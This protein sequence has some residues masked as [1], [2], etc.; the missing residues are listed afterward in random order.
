MKQYILLAIVVLLTLFLPSRL[1]KSLR[2]TAFKTVSRTVDQKAGE[3]DR[4][5]S[6]NYALR[7]QLERVRNW[8]VAEESLERLKDFES[9]IK[10]NA[11]SANVVHREPGSWGAA[12]WIDR[13]EN[14]Q[15]KEES[16]VLVNGGV[17]GVVEEVEKTRSRVRL[18]TD[19]RLVPSVRV[20]RGALQ[21]R[22]LIESIEQLLQQL[23]LRPEIAS[24]LPDE[25][26]GLKQTLLGENEN[27]YLAK[28]E[29]HGASGPLWH[30]LKSELTGLGFNYEFPD[31]N[32]DCRPLTD[33]SLLKVGDL[34]V[35]TGMD[36]VFPP[37]L[38]IAVITKVD[39]LHDGQVSYS[40][41]ASPYVTSIAD[42]NTVQV[43][44][45]H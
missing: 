34:L 33:S 45:V 5:R 19:S 40:L 12:L 22:A 3:L 35:T 15:I 29:L 37:D 44:S 42:I 18:I 13:G 1:V 25:L 4:L 16:P 24:Y 26:E 31:E 27:H 21:N 41:R 17:V 20:S 32:G 30:S 8:L 38:P 6:E 39:P 9:R 28:G 11:L 14:D 23:K 10:W 2:H 36:G 43:L 7:N